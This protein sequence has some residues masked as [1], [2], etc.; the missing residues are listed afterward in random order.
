MEQPELTPKPTAAEELSKRSGFTVLTW[1]LWRW[2]TLP[3]L[4]GYAYATVVN[5]KLH[6]PTMYLAL[7]V[8]AAIWL[9]CFAAKPPLFVGRRKNK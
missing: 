2:A 7:G 5:P 6:D 8:A 1:G 3:V 9:V 4:L